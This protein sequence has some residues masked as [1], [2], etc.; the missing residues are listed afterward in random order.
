MMAEL[1]RALWPTAC[2]SFAEIP[3]QEEEGIRTDA[4]P[5]CDTLATGP[6]GPRRHRLASVSGPVQ[7]TPLRSVRAEKNCDLTP[8]THANVVA[9]CLTVVNVVAWMSLII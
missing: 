4:R 1:S 8:R 6:Q 2:V 5:T 9:L 7:P 3:D